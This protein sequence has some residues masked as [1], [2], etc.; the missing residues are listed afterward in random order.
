MKVL[1]INGSP[2][3]NGCTHTALDEVSGALN[4]NGVETEILSLGKK[5]VQGCIACGYCKDH[6]GC[7]FKDDLVNEVIQK[8]DTVD[9]IVLGSPVYYAAASGQI[10]SFADRLFF[11]GAG[12]FTGKVGAS[13]VSARR[14]GTTASLDQLNKYFSISGMPIA[15]ATY[16]N[17][18][19][20]N[21]PEEMKQDLEGMQ[22]LRVL[23]QNMAWLIKCIEH[24]KREGIT[25]PEL[26]EV[27][28]RTNF[29]R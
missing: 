13:V 12:K 8:L 24:G 6:E 7:V 14:A 10:S 29:V 21:T 25:Y 17:Q 27:K 1:L 2:N 28:A 11:A 19:H 23:G 22:N 15:S 16:W 4:K 9:G 26:K 3:P 18:V 5:A 20:G